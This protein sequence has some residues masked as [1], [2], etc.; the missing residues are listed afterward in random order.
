MDYDFKQLFPHDF[1]QLSRDL[2]QARDGIILESFKAGRDQGIDFRHACATGADIIVQ[3]KHYAAT[4]L[5]GLITK[6]KSEIGNLDKLK[7]LISP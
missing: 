5:G 3:C 6:L 2:I 1:E 4:G 7:L